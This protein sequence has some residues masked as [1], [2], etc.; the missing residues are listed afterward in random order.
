MGLFSKITSF[1]RKN[2]VSQPQKINLNQDIIEIN[3]EF[4]SID[5]IGFFGRSYI[6][7]NNLWV[8]GCMDSDGHGRGGHRDKGNGKV[9]LIDYVSKKIIHVVNE[10]ERP[11]DADIS[12]IGTYI[13]NDSK[14]NLNLESD[15]IA[16]DKDKNELFRRKY[17]ANIYNLAISNCGGYAIV[18]TCNSPSKD[19]DLL[20]LINIKNKEIIFSI[21]PLTGWAD[22]YIFNLENDK[23][24]S[25]SIIYNELG[26][27]KYSLNG[28]F[29]DNEQY[30][31]ALL[32]F[33]DY[34]TKI[35]AARD[36]IK[37]TPSQEDTKKALKAIESA[38]NKGALND[39]NWLP[40]AY[41]VQGEAY[42]LL[43]D[44]YAALD[45]FDK[46]LA[47]APKI[48]IKK[49]ADKLRKKIVNV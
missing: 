29:I 17:Q 31:N 7:Q 16:I 48:G 43:G 44:N 13:I 30:N 21:N 46:A 37:N 40:I 5:G 2:D 20:E 45:S 36:L 25:I 14:F 4:L 28:E 15:L 3:D 18:Q 19:G 22:K 9:V 23:L 35:M 38:I 47:L 32:E 10:I 8:V 27:F 1:F 26:D 6:S 42:E 41:R 12:N 49:K 33:G 34:S 24:T 11:F 39:K